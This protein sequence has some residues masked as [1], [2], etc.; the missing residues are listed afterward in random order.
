[1]LAAFVVFAAA[2]LTDALD[3]FL[4]RRFGWESVLGAYLDALAD[5][6]LLVSVYASLGILGYLPPS[7]VILV[8]SRDILII[9]AYLLTWLLG[10]DIGVYPTTI[11]KVNTLVQISLAALVLINDAVSIDLDRAEILLIWSCG[12]TTAFSAALYIV[13]W[14]RRMAAYDHEGCGSAKSAG[15]NRTENN[16]QGRL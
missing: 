4:A 6:A 14:A 15:H 7:L 8:I 11:S 2:G 1:M 13:I 5:K 9:G 3:G 16:G 12:L 10:R